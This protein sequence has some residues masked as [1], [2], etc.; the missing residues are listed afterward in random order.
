MDTP[1]P[2]HLCRPYK[3]VLLGTVQ[4]FKQGFRGGSV[5]IFCKGAEGGYPFFT[6][7]QKKTEHGKM[8]LSGNFPHRPGCPFA[9]FASSALKSFRHP[10]GDTH[11]WLR[12]RRGGGVPKFKSDLQNTSICLGPQAT[13]SIYSPFQSHDFNQPITYILAIN[14][15]RER[16]LLYNNLCKA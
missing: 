12:L 14:S 13:C 7:T 10:G 15:H 2:R 4:N 16:M 11:F 5:W 6:H 9:R 8:P 1:L 3:L